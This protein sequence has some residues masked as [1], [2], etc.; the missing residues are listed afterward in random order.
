MANLWTGVF[1]QNLGAGRQNCGKFAGRQKPS[2][3]QDACVHW[4]WYQEDVSAS[5]CLRCTTSKTEDVRTPL[6]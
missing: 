4:T 1:Q 6:L 5:V 3:T 2:S